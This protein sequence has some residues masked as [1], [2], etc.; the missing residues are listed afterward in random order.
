[1][2]TTLVLVGRGAFEVSIGLGGLSSCQC[3]QPRNQSG[4][5]A[6]SDQSFV[7]DL[8]STTHF[9]APFTATRLITLPGFHPSGL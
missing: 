7:V 9:F 5:L 4:L 2:L 3:G 8:D 6:H 1:M